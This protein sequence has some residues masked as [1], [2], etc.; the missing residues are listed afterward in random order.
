M[1]LSHSNFMRRCVDSITAQP[2]S[3]KAACGSVAAQHGD[4][5]RRRAYQVILD[6]ELLR[7]E[8]HLL[9]DLKALEAALAALLLQLLLHMI[10]RLLVRAQLLQHG[11]HSE[12]Q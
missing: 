6:A 11:V 7:G 8:V 10:R 2:C 9:D 12:W 5:E 1:M 4:C 3:A